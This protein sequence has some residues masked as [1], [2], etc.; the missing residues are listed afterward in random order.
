MISRL[1]SDFKESDDWIEYL[2][3]KLPLERQK[4]YNI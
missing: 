4:E 2:V 3:S 1:V